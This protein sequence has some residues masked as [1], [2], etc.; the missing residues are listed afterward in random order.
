M[1]TTLP[2]EGIVAPAVSRM[3]PDVDETISLLVSLGC[4]TV[5]STLFGR[6]T[7]GTKM[8]NINYARGLVI[9]LYLISWMF[10][11]MATQ[12][13]QTNDYNMV[14]CI[15]SI[16]TCIV[17]YAGSKI[18]IYL[19]LMEKVY[20]VTAI[21]LTRSNFWL[22][23]VNLMLLSPYL[24]IVALMVIFRVHNI[25]EDGQC[26]IGLLRPAALPL[27]LYDMF[28]SVWLTGLFIQPLISSKSMLQGPSKGRLRDVARRTMIGALMALVLS[29]A[30]VFTVVYFEG[31]E[32]GLLCLSCCTADVTLNAIT[33]H[34]VTS[35]GAL[36]M[37]ETGHEKQGGGGYVP[38]GGH[39]GGGYVSQ[40]LMS[41]SEKQVGPVE[42]HITVEAY[43][44]EF[45][46]SSFYNN[47]KTNSNSNSSGGGGS[48]GPPSRVVI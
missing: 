27:I 35:R 18:I 22:Y 40:H 25:N 3:V 20:V 28:I 34:W 33:I 21:G 6:K 15:I 30:N 23:R 37:D 43:V 41:F 11:L 42:S 4:I 5:M 45:H 7:A 9:A 46:S 1:S 19:F 39:G 10:S 17:L 24:I 48:N 47:N 12:L 38:R 16:Y 2:N 29:S 36:Q 32:R 26:H 13:V 14:S 44:D 8:T 31:N